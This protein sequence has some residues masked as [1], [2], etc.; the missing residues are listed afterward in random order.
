MASLREMDEYS[1]GYASGAPS[2]GQL[3]PELVARV[4]REIGSRDDS[5]R[6]VLLSEFLCAAWP[7]PLCQL[8]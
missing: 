5:Q 3:A 7:S 6:Q 2:E 8:Q 1:D 4:I